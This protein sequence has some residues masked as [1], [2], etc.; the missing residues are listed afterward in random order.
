MADL[1]ANLYKVRIAR[2]GRGKSSGFRTLLVYKY[3]YR[4]IFL[5]GFAKNE[6]DNISS[7]ELTA[8]KKLGDGWL[9]ASDE[10]LKRVL[11]MKALL[12]IRG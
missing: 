5:Y 9:K 6:R 4:A 2:P 11:M 8:F 7:S 1:G 10:E 3:A 12:E